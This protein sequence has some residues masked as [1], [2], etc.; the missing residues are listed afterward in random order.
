MVVFSRTPQGARA[1][2][3][4]SRTTKIEPMKCFFTRRLRWS[5]AAAAGLFCLAAAGGGASAQRP[6]AAVVISQAEMR[7]AP[8]TTLLVATVH[9]NRRSRVSSEGMGRVVEMTARQGDFLQAGAVICRL[10]DETLTLRVAEE[11]AR[12]QMLAARLAELEAG[13]RPQELDRARADF[14]AADAIYQQWKFE[15]DRVRDLYAGDSSNDKEFRDTQ[16]MYTSAERRRASAEAELRLLEE[17]PR[18]EVI[19]QARHEA[20]AQ[21]A[22][23]ARFRTDLDKLTVKAP[24]T[25]F[26]V[27]RL[28]EVGEWVSE[29]GAVADMVDLETVLV[30]LDLPEAA[31]PHIAED[32]PA[33]VVVDALGRTFPGTVR[34]IMRQA[35]TG[36][37]TFPV[38]IEVANKDHL[39]AGGM[40]ARALVTTGP[41]ATVLAVPKDAVVERDG[42]AFVVILMPGERGLM[43]MPQPVSV[44]PDI[45]DWVAVTSAALRPGAE[46]VIRGNENIAY[47][48]PVM[49]VD[50]R[51][52]PVAP[53]GGSAQGPPGG[54]P[55]GAA[56]REGA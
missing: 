9:P 20:A 31:L 12:H 30:R 21:Q 37:R 53:P 35:R 23:V 26:I 10:N 43:G 6:P 28:A 3:V 36:A 48:M 34:H 44:G 42:G 15:L 50:E 11:E 55:A 25:G 40:F 13:T 22:V 7:E 52:V 4:L 45:G 49:V 51:G 27:D 38:E 19:A 5:V 17:G 39:L 8:S 18:K 1:S 41:T 46:V 2:R 54:A 32:Q 47:P 56:A 29:G 24:F 33:K 16:A 14:E